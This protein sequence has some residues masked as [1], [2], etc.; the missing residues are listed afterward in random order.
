MLHL[1]RHGAPEVTGLML[2]HRD[3][4]VSAAGIAA[5]VA[6][7]R[8]IVAGAIITSDLARAADCAR[9]IGA[10]QRLQAASDP[11]WRELDFGVWDGLPSAEIYAD[12][13]AAFWNDPD[14]SPPPGGE[15]WSGLRARVA[16]ALS[17][18]TEPTLVVTHAGAIRA[19]LSVLCGFDYRQGW[20]I[21]LPYAGLVTLRLWREPSAAA[22]II[23]LRP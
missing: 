23:A 7:A 3:V 21:D 4:P 10:D 13:L 18:I 17:A 6:Q 16:E 1:M 22:Q 15:R 2:G 11:R 8:N 20:A 12:A 14:A 5:C 19:A 9:Q